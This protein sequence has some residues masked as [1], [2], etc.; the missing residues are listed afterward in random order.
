MKTI[1]FATQFYTL[2]DVQ[3]SPVYQS[4]D[5]GQ[6]T[7]IGHNYVYTYIKN[8]SMDLDKVNRLYPEL[9]IDHSLCGITGREWTKFVDIPV[10]E[11]QFPFGMYKGTEIS[12]CN[13]VWQLM[14]CYEHGSTVFGPRRKVLARRKLIELG[15]LVRY[16]WLQC[17]DARHIGEN[18]EHVVRCFQN[19][20]YA[21]KSIVLDE[22]KRKAEELRKAASEYYFTD[23]QKVELSVKEVDR[24]SFETQYGY[25][26]ILTLVEE[27]TLRLFKYMGSAPPNLDVDEFNKVSCTI[28]HKEY[29]GEKQTLLQRIKILS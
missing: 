19:R 3:V 25:T 16:D 10:T 24:F 15:E 8:I 2:W 5:R 7:L 12:E 23:G 6:H 22:E 14:R 9:S 13:D 1:G 11:T 21:T 28:K 4:N 26:T 20:K 17:I 29:R 27:N 18:E